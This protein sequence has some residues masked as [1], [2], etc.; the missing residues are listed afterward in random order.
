MK[1]ILSL[2]IVLIAI[3]QVNASAT[4]PHSPV[5][6]S[7]L[8]NGPLVKVFYQGEETGKVKVTIYNDKGRIVYTE[9]MRDTENFMR[10][11]NF[12]RLP[13]GKYTIE[14]IDS[15][16]KRVKEIA[17]GRRAKENVAVLTKLRQDQGKYMLA[18]PNEGRNALTVRIFDNY[19]KLVYA[20]TEVVEGDFATVYDLSKFKGNYTFEV[21]D[22][23]GNVVRLK[24]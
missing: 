11:Y 17:H 3:G 13:A 8:K 18:V 9:T 14:L 1:K 6:M 22:G 20:K 19:S 21:A 16:G 12:S 15:H 23:N 4:E 24:K 10:P 5:G 2:V 7:V